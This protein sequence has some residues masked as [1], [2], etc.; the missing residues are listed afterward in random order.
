MKSANEFTV[1]KTFRPTSMSLISTPKCRWTSFW[2]HGAMSQAITVIP[3]IVFAGAYD[4][5]FRAYDARTGKIVWDV[6]TGSEP[7]MTLSGRTAYGGVMDG[8]AAAGG[9]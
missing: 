9:T 3:G 2:C 1:W 6:D 8:A 4:G 7:V 5:H